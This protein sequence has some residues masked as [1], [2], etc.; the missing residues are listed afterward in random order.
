MSMRRGAFMQSIQGHMAA[1]TSWERI[2]DC[3][4]DG[5]F[6]LDGSG[7]VIAVNRAYEVMSGFSREEIVGIDCVEV[8]RKPSRPETWTGFCGFSG[9]RSRARTSLPP[10]QPSRQRTAGKN[11]YIILLL[12]SGK[13]MES[14]RRSFRSSRT[15][16]MSPGPKSCCR[17]ASGGSRHSWTTATS[18]PG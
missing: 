4:G 1:M 12:S 5:L 11:R 2:I 3:V 16:A 17:R 13:T 9:T 8:A 14:Q 7:T 10:V 18:S 15:S 6:L